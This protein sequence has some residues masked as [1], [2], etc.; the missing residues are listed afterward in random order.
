M[1]FSISF[2]FKKIIDELGATQEQANRAVG[3]TLKKLAQRAKTTGVEEVTKEYNITRANLLTTASDKARIEI[4]PYQVDTE[5]GSV[6]LRV[7]GKSISLSYFGA[8]QTSGSSMLFRKGK[9]IAR[10]NNGM[11]SRG[12]AGT[13]VEILRGGRRIMLKGSFLAKMKNGHIGVYAREGKAK[14]KIDE[15]KMVSLATLF[16]GKKVFPKI[17]ERLNAESD[18]LFRHELEYFMGKL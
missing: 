3:S 11:F 6:L 8:Q 2:D 1:L 15:R 12:D 9:N 14:L 4:M 18:D 16:G 17:E 10:N 13:T 5:G 7:K